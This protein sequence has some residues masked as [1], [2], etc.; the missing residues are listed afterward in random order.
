MTEDRKLMLKDSWIDGK[1]K[2]KDF[3]RLTGLS[4]AK[5]RMAASEN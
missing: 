1:R 2:R 3:K 5:T 4:R